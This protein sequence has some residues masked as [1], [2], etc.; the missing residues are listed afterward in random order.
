MGRGCCGRGVSSGRGQAGKGVRGGRRVLLGGCGVQAACMH[1][2]VR[3]L[4]CACVC[5]VRVSGRGGR[6]LGQAL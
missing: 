1:M 3:V 5:H 2:R 4:V 6:K